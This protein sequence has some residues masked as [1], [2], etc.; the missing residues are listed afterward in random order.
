MTYSLQDARG[1]VSYG[2]SIAGMK[3][4]REAVEAAPTVFPDLRSFVMKGVTHSPALLA[5]QA[6]F[7]TGVASKPIRTTLSNIIRSAKR[8]NSFLALTD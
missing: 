6:E 3:A 7:R 4:L 2:P 5:E 8:A 1:Y